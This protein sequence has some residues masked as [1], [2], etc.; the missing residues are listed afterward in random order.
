MPPA[1][2]YANVARIEWIKFLIDLPRPLGEVVRSIPP[3]LRP[4][5]ALFHPLHFFIAFCG[6]I[7]SNMP[8][9]NRIITIQAESNNRVERTGGI[10]RIGFA[11][12]HCVPPVAHPWGSPFYSTLRFLA[13]HWVLPP[14]LLHRSTVRRP[15]PLGWKYSFP[16][17][18][19]FDDVQQQ[20]KPSQPSE[21]TLCALFWT[22]KVKLVPQNFV[23]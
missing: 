20:Q 9:R 19:Y 17:R 22:R 21:K 7:W 11:I 6:A 4:V 13:R 14:V 15:S 3:Y 23:C 8:F 10:R 16:C 2:D 1:H 18:R 12:V 5:Y